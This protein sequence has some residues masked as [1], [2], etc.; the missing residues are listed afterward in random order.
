MLVVKG[1]RIVVHLT[2]GK[3]LYASA[4]M[5]DET[6][7]QWPRTSVLLASFRKIGTPLDDMTY[8]GEDYTPHEGVLEI[9]G[10]LRAVKALSSWRLVG[11]AIEID[12]DRKGGALKGV[13][14]KDY[15]PFKKNAYKHDF[16]KPVN[17]YRHRS[18]KALRIE[19]G[20]SA[21]LNWKGFIYP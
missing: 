19:L 2:A 18:G 20:P 16:K 13:S 6:G 9:Q 15:E 5:H 12:Y 17:V 10:E 3:K 8:F 4:M 7:K 14:E 1:R 21:R 11:Q